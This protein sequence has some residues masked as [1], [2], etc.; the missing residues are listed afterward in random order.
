M[1]GSCVSF[2]VV[3]RRDEMLTEHLFEIGTIMYI[4]GIIGMVYALYHIYK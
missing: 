4:I 1:L 2:S 3:W